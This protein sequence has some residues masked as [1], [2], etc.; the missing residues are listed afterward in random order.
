MPNDIT[1]QLKYAQGVVA[2]G[3]YNANVP[4]IG[5]KQAVTSDIASLQ[6]NGAIYSTGN[7]AQQIAA[8][9]AAVT[10]IQNSAL[11]QLNAGTISG[12]QYSALISTAG[13]AGTTA[14]QQAATQGPLYAQYAGTNNGTPANKPGPTIGSPVIS[15]SVGIPGSYYSTLVKEQN[16]VKTA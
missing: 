6:D 13:A 5:N 3:A 10:G 1:D 7:A 11:A 16:G 9:N 8:R 14:A 2:T 15:P 12:A 4:V